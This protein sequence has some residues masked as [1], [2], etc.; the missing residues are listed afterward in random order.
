[1]HIERTG[2]ISADTDA[3]AGLDE[4]TGGLFRVP[5]F[6]RRV[7]EVRKLVKVLK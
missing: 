1:M 7:P 3:R 5:Y 4:L 6:G 2:C